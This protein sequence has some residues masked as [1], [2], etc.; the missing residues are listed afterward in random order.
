MPRR[1]GRTRT[2]LART[3]QTGTSPRGT[4]PAPTAGA[5]RAAAYG[6][7]RPTRPRPLRPRAALRA[8]ARYGPSRPTSPPRRSTGP[9]VR[10]GRGPGLPGDGGPSWPGPAGRG[11]AAGGGRNGGRRSRGRGR[12]RRFFRLRTVRVI[13]A[14]IAVFCCWVAFSVG[15]ALTAPGGGSISS[16]L[17]E[18][19]RDHYLGPVVTFGE[20]ISYQP[21]KV[22]GTPGFSLAAAGAPPRPGT[23]SARTDSCRTSRRS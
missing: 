10:A 21:P 4:N 16:K 20:W 7:S 13:L 18:W 2:G 1:T 6:P 22:G 17:A 23:T 3:S 19:A 14:L 5:V 9:S 8:R 11:T 15:Q 12:I